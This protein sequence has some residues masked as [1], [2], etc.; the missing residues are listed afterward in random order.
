MSTPTTVDAA[1]PQVADR[2]DANEVRLTERPALADLH[3]V[4]RLCDSGRLRCSDKT[5]RPA[6]ASVVTVAETLSGGDFYP[7]E[8]IAAYAWPLLVQAGG[9]AEVVGGK[10][11]LTARGRTALR[12]PAADIVKGLW[13]SWVSKAILDELSR[14]DNIKG[15]RTTNVLTSA[16]TRRQQVSAALASCHPGDWIAVDDLF[17]AMRRAGLSPTVA[18]S[19]RA[20]WRLYLIDPQ[21]GSLG[22]AGFGEWEI[23]EGR[24][25]LAVIFEYAATL[26]LVDVAYDDP[27]GA[28]VDY[29]GNWGAD[30]FDYLSRYDGLR[31]VRLTGLGAYTLDLTPSY[32][33][34]AETA[35]TQSLKVLPSLD[36]VAVG[37][38]SPADRL[39]LDA[40]AKQTSDRVWALTSE[41]VLAAVAAGR[42]VAELRDFLTG[43]MAQPELPG[44]L[45]VLLD[46][47][48]ARVGQLRDLGQVRLIECAD[49]AVAAL[50]RN[51]RRLQPLCTAVGDRHL[52]VTPDQEPGFRRALQKLG[53]ALPIPGT[54]N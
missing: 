4:L 39:V 14:V 46:D 25:T 19:E 44:T 7:D 45:L 28:R 9:L 11:Q 10:L 2:P 38:L 26:G 47:A 43:R 42:G 1:V 30:D 33:A 40:Y 29:H 53:Y 34:P 35:P 36:V 18:R 5:K 6:A 23:L 15:Q 48:T 8:A 52:A 20:L 49:P 41:T 22:Y 32:A 31:A 54:R 3:A 12:K 51:D 13:R 27:A 17:A 16:K 37:E 21:Y 50:I 24:Y